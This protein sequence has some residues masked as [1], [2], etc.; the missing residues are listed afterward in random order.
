MCPPCKGL[1]NCSICRNR[2]GKGA[3]GI[4]INI[5]KAKGFDNVKD[6]LESLMK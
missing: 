2:N 6:Y 5:A 1:C 4:L 3:T